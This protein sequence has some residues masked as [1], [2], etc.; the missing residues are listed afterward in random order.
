MRSFA[1]TAIST[2]CAT[3]RWNSFDGK[4]GL[5]ML[6]RLGKTVPRS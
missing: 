2:A 3:I 4:F 5:T 1:L 6:L